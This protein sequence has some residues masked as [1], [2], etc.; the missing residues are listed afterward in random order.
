MCCN[1]RKNI[2]KLHEV[3]FK[4]IITVAKLCWISNGI[5][6]LTFCHQC[7]WPRLG[8]TIGDRAVWVHMLRSAALCKSSKHF[9][10]L[11]LH[12]TPLCFCFSGAT[13]L[14]WKINVLCSIFSVGYVLLKYN[15]R[16]FEFYSWLGM[17]SP[18]AREP[19]QLRFHLVGCD[20]NVGCEVCFDWASW[21]F[22]MFFF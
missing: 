9:A 22:L 18:V 21:A 11:P 13:R 2:C 5:W 8:S 10:L 6:R 4:W 12:L 7:S 3:R 17:T 19:L 20:P 14:P 16:Q 15:L 1:V